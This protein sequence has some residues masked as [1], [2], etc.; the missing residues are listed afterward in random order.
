MVVDSLTLNTLSGVHVRVRNSDRAAV[1]DLNGI[2]AIVLYPTDTMIFSF[3]GYHKS[4][5]PAQLSDDIMIVRLH[6]DNIMLKEV[7]IRDR[8]YLNRRLIHSNTLSTTKPLKAGSGGSSL[9]GAPSFGVNFAYF[10]REEKE[11]RKLVAVMRELELVRV[12]V[13]IVNDPAFRE[14]VMEQNSLS[15]SRF[16]ELLAAFNQKN[17][18]LMRSGHADLIRSSLFFYFEREARN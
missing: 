17:G 15:E 6:E 18:D 7:V 16:Y 13:D 10:T 12:Y 1:S 14:E 5:L 4:I 8:P 3:V 11:K 2:F 9:N